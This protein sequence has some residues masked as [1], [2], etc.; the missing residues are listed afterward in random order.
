MGVGAADRL[1]PYILAQVGQCCDWADLGNLLRVSRA[2]HQRLDEVLSVIHG[3]VGEQTL[4]RCAEQRMFLLGLLGPRAA[5]EAADA[6]D[7]VV[8][9]RSEVN[10][11]E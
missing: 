6:A 1:A 9:V 7:A 2:A 11:F 3:I 10:N 4:A 5:G 8:T